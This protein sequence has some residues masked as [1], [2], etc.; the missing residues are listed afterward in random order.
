[1]SRARRETSAG[2]IIFRPADAGPQYLLILDGN[3]NWGFPKGH[4]V[5]GETS[6]EA[7]RREIAEETGLA[8]LV[9]HGE[10]GVIDWFFRAG[11]S[12]V[13]K[14]CHLFLFESTAGDV[15]PQVDEGITACCWHS[16]E[17]ALAALTHE[18]ART[19]LRSA[20]QAVRRQG[21]GREPAREP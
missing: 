6:L 8:D 17:A 4:L 1:M 9:L 7:A 20:G 5:P 15:V 16:L 14:H 11:G 3:G 13:H 12:L 10:L 18:N 2:G 19:V 21:A